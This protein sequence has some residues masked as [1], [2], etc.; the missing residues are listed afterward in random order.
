MMGY[1]PIQDSHTYMTS[2]FRSFSFHKS[3]TIPP[4]GLLGIGIGFLCPL[5]V[6]SSAAFLSSIGLTFFTNATTVYPLIAIL[7]GI[8][9]I[10][11]V[12]GLKVHGDIAPLLFGTIGIF[13]LPFGRYLL[14]SALLTY[15]SA[16]CILAAG[17]WNVTVERATL[18][19]STASTDSHTTP[20]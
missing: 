9:F 20:Q 8:F 17:F 15:T 14:H 1:F 2:F 16:F 19:G 4:G 3:C 6:P 10:G 7:S 11:L 18:R 13:M 5:C 12:R